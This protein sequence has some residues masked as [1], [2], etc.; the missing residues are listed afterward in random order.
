MF[1]NDP[2]IQQTVNAVHLEALQPTGTA[3]VALCKSIIY[4]QV[5]NKTGTTIYNRFVD[6]LGLDFTAE[7]L[8][9]CSQSALQTCGI[10]RQKY[11]YLQNIAVHYQEN[12]TFWQGIQEHDANTILKELCTIKG[13]GIWTVQMLLIF[14]LQFPDIVPLNDLVIKKQMMAL[15]NIQST[16]TQCQKDLAQI[17]QR[18]SPN[19]SLASRAL[20]IWN[21]QLNQKDSLSNLT[22]D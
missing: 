8:V 9:S 14:H 21:D 16:G 13:V 10:S 18:W 2:Q 7:K 6:L 17:A 20:W 12:P 19:G 5:S 1:S 11:H 22:K 3:F 4:Q 15:Y